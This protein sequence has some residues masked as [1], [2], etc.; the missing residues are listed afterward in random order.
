MIRRFQIKV[1][2]AKLA[3]IYD[4]KE[5]KNYRYGILLA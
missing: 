4:E 3:P 5:S 1:E 2:S